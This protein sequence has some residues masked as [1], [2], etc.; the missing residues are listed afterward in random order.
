MM[1]DIEQHQVREAARPEGQFIAVAGQ[2]QPRVREQVG[3]KRIRQVRLEIADAGADL[4][5]APRDGGVN[6]GQD[7]PIEARID[8]FE[9]RLGLPGAQVALDLGLV[10][11]E[12]RRHGMNFSRRAANNTMRNSSQ[13]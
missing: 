6:E 5:D 1:K 9:Q 10:L 4:D 12:R 2:V 8:L 3:G 7:A 13:P 11:R